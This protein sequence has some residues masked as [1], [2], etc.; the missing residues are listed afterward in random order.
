MKSAT[1]QACQFLLPQIHVRETA[2]PRKGKRGPRAWSLR[3]IP[4]SLISTMRAEYEALPIS[5]NG[6]KPYGSV[7]VLAEKYGVRY[8]YACAIL[9]LG[10]RDDEREPNRGISSVVEQS[11]VQRQ[12]EGSNPSCPATTLKKD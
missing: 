10:L 1:F 2:A 12:V 6:R 9:C 8:N 4:Q 7:K 3:K 11:P 5:P